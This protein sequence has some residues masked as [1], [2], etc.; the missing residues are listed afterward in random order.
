MLTAREPAMVR[1]TWANAGFHMSGQNVGPGQ[2]MGGYR[3]TI[4]LRE[5]EKQPVTSA[6]TL[7]LTPEVPGAM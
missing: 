7:I 4:F 1:H 2:N 5:V 6:E 3:M